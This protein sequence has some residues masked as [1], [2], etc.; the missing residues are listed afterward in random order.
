MKT[1]NILS[2]DDMCIYRMCNNST[3]ESIIKNV[4]S[5]FERSRKQEREFKNFSEEDKRMVNLINEEVAKELKGK[6]FINGKPIEKFNKFSYKV[7]EEG[8]EFYLE[9]GKDRHRIN[10]RQKEKFLER[11]F[12][13][14]QNCNLELNKCIKNKLFSE[15]FLDYVINDNRNMLN[16]C[17]DSLIKVNA[18]NP[19]MDTFKNKKIDL[20]KDFEIIENYGKKKISECIKCGVYTRS[21]KKIV[22]CGS[23]KKEGFHG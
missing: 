14:M 17:S 12:C 15:D 8:Q 21:N 7:S 4:F 13:V 3:E 1:L 22:I 23:C 20:L 19:I 18:L 16:N 6:L 9:I 11:I 10:K 2:N 5:K